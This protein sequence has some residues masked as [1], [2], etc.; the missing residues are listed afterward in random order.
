MMMTISSY[1]RRG[2]HSLKALALDPRVHLAGKRAAWVVSG[3]V[4]SGAGL[5]GS[6]QTVALGLLC[7]CS[8]TEALLVAMGAAVGYWIFWGAA[9]LQGQLWT[10]LGLLSAAT[11]GDRRITREVPL[12]MPSLAGLIVSASGV[13]F[14]IWLADNTSV[15]IYLLRV[16]MGASTTYLFMLVRQRR[17]PVADWMVCGLGVLAGIRPIPYFSLGMIAAGALGA[18]GA[19]PAA[20]LAGLALDL[21]DITPA[22]MTAVLCL[23]YF[24]RMIP[25]QPR[26]LSYCMP[27]VVYIIVA[28][29]CGVHDMRPLPALMMGGGLGYFLPEQIKLS[30]RRGETGV[31]QVRLEITAGVF[32]QMEQ[33]LLETTEP[34]VDENTLIQRAAERACGTCAN[35]K[36]CR[37]RETVTRMS[38]DMLHR[39]LFTDRDFPISCRKTGRLVN[40][41]RRSQ[42]QLRNLRAAR[43]RMQECRSAVVQQYQFMAEYL[44]ELSDSVAQRRHE[45]AQRYSVEVAVYSNRREADNGDRCIWFAGTQCRY[46]VLMCDGMGT[47][48]GAVEEGKTA[49]NLLKKPLPVC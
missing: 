47:G 23:V 27:G 48:L 28:W 32:G 11:L 15:P 37:E 43:E 24:S 7:A 38:V 31:A 3:L 22:P 8:G 1:V 12:L 42:E 6:P 5:G 39:P 20:A 30:H 10:V 34:P 45:P 17:D 14:Q 46:Y 36:N 4:L 18:A 9:G 35:R 49:A 33:L 21:A 26:W 29:L 40:E 25:R 2:R 16:G 19:F 44:M 41:V 13:L